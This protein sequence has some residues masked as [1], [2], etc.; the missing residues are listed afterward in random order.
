[1]KVGLINPGSEYVSNRIHQ[2]L[3]YINGISFIA[4]ALER[5]GHEV[6]TV[7]F[8]HD[9]NASLRDVADCPV[10]GVSSILES[11][12]FLKKV[13]PELKRGGKQI[14]VGGPLISSYGRSERNVLM[15]AFPEIDFGVIGEGELTAPRLIRFLEGR[16][17]LPEGLVYRDGNELRSTGEPEVVHDL[18]DLPPVNFGRWK[19]LTELVQNDFFNV[20]QLARGCYNRCSFC[21]LIDT[22]HGIRSY[23]GKRMEKEMANVLSLN[24]KGLHFSDDTFS[25]SKERAMKVGELLAKKGILYEIQTRVSDVDLELMKHLKDTGCIWARFGIES[26]DEDVLKRCGKNITKDQI[27]RAIEI[28]KEAG[29]GAMGFFIFGLPGE[30]RKSIE[31]TIRGI[32]E[33]EIIPRARILIP[34]PGTRVYSEALARGKIKDE[35]ALLRSYPQQERGGDTVAGNF[36]PINMADNLTDQELVEA[37]DRANGL[38]DDLSEKVK[39]QNQRDN[40]AK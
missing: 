18:D 29:I 35:L 37:R 16:G 5:A 19:G 20:P 10:V 38:R 8:A 25:Y 11:Y 15:R 26:F 4:E 2:N 13:L 28:T 14:I 33:T 31:T 34:L 24:P 3:V 27:Y 30:T 1:M 39:D 12:D 6:K 40:L 32:E 7:N 21:Y 36:V 23:S 22:R 9:P 17:Q